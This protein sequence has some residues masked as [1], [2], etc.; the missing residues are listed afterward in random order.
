MSSRSRE[1]QTLRAI[2]RSSERFASDQQR[3]AVAEELTQ[4]LNSARLQPLDRRRLL[5]F[6]HV[7]RALETTLLGACQS[8][9]LPPPSVPSMVAYLNQLVG[10]SPAALPQAVRDNC[11]ARVADVRNRLAHAAGAYPAGDL[12]LASGFD[13]ARACLA[14]LLA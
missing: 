4:F 10:C 2:V 13:A 12:Q 5:Q 14:L 8:R 7:S 9:H 1:A 3:D 11:K 6:I